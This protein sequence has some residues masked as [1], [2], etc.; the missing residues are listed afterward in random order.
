MIEIIQGDTSIAI[1]FP[2]LKA[3]GNWPGDPSAV[4]TI[5]L[6]KNG[7]PKVPAQGNVLPVAGTGGF[8]FYPAAGDVD[9]LGPVL[10]FITVSSQDFAPWPGYI[11]KPRSW[12]QDFCN[13]PRNIAANAVNSRLIAKAT[14]P[15]NQQGLIQ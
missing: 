5:Q 11:V 6:S 3:S 13:I 15:P 2:V 8:W 1:P 4:P 9:T 14:I 7:G 10:M 12:W